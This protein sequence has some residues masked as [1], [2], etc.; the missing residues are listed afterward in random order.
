MSDSNTANASGAAK[1]TESMSQVLPLVTKRLKQHG[2]SKVCVGYDGA[3]LRVVFL[4]NDAG[5]STVAITV[6]AT[7]EITELF[8]RILR[9]RYPK[10]FEDDGS[11][12]LFEWDVHADTLRHD[13][14]ITQH[15][16]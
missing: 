10:H 3:K 11:T 16:L 13:H 14:I 8:S 4:G 1:H 9:R 15:G 2:I 6:T 7:A 5:S 12:G